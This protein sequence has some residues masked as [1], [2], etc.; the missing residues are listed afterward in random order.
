MSTSEKVSP[1]KS[2]TKGQY[3]QFANLSCY[4]WWVMRMPCSLHC[5]H[6][7]W[8]E[9]YSN[10]IH[11]QVTFILFWWS[12]VWVIENIWIRKVYLVLDKIGN[13]EIDWH[14]HTLPLQ[15]A[16]MGKTSKTFR[17][18]TFYIIVLLNCSFVKVFSYWMCEN[19]HQMVEF[20]GN[21]L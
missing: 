7:S 3:S 15:E 1:M 20:W 17:E 11:I 5:T 18:S 4:M 2:R 9:N 19:W 16:S 21:S 12:T 10:C 14:W 8:K 13:L 6:F